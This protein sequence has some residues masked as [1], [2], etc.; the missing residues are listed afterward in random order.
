[1][2]KYLFIKKLLVLYHVN[3]NKPLKKY[4]NSVNVYFGCI[5]LR[6]V[7]IAEIVISSAY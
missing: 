2:L 5:G 6:D 1:M 4:F 3:I 7:H